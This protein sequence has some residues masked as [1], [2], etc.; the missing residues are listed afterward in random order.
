MTFIKAFKK[1]RQI[2]K[3]EAELRKNLR[4]IRKADLSYEC[5]SKLIENVANSVNGVT[6]DVVFSDGTKMT[7][8]QSTRSEINFKSFQDQWKE[9]HKA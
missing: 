5:L 9:K 1:A 7:I 4:V 6:L 8:R 3:E 2:L